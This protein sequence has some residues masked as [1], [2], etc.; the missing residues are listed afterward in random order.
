[1]LR[2]S[3]R[4]I[5]DSSNFVNNIDPYAGLRIG[6]IVAE[7]NFQVETAFVRN[8]HIQL[9]SR[10]RKKPGQFAKLITTRA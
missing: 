4:V 6:F 1:M 9:I 8:R 7:I 10:L 2:F 5:A 3:G